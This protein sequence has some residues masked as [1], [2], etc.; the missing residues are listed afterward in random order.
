MLMR[1]DLLSTTTVPSPPSFAIKNITESQFSVVWEQPDYLAGIV[2]DYKI[3][4]EWKPL[5]PIP[6]WCSL[7][8]PN[9]T[10]IKNLNDTQSY[11]YCKAKAYSQY[12]VKM[13]ARTG[14][15]WGNFS[16]IQTIQSN[17]AS[18]CFVFYFL[19]ILL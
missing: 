13:Q 11:D 4:L 9:N 19:F 12:Q 18:M 2:K 17:S 10:E 14:A 7:E 5:F 6:T 16:A 3:S 8:L 15:G 1:L